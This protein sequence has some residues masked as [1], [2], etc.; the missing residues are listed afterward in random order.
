[1]FSVKRR[2]TV[3]F[4]TL[5]ICPVS[6][7]YG[8]LFLQACNAEI[9]LEKPVCNR[10]GPGRV[11]YRQKQKMTCESLGRRCMLRKKPERIQ[12]VRQHKTEDRNLIFVW[13]KVT[14]PWIKQSS[15]NKGKRIICKKPRN[16]RID[17]FFRF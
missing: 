8:I 4:Y 13:D 12:I 16:N 15:P 11:Y 14:F 6:G 1:M 17:S 10:Y 7:E 9:E 2:N 3:S 5:S